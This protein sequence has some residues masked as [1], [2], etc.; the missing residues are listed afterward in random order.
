VYDYADEAWTPGAAKRRRLLG[1][2]FGFLT[3]ASKQKGGREASAGDR[4]KPSGKKESAATGSSLG[5][6]PSSQEVTETS[7]QD[8]A[9]LEESAD[10]DADAGFELLSSALQQATDHSAVRD[11]ESGGLQ[12]ETPCSSITLTGAT[13]SSGQRFRRSQE[14]QEN[15]R[16][17]FLVL[18]L[19]RLDP[20]A[21]PPNMHVGRHAAVI[22]LNLSDITLSLRDD[23]A[24]AQ[25]SLDESS[26]ADNQSSSSSTG[27]VALTRTESHSA[28]DGT[29]RLDGHSGRQAGTQSAG[30][31]A[32]EEKQAQENEISC[33]TTAACQRDKN[34]LWWEPG[35][36][37]STRPPLTHQ[38]VAA[39]L[40]RITYQLPIE[41]DLEV[42]WQGVRER[43]EGEKLGLCLQIFHLLEGAGL[44]GLSWKE[45]LV[46]VY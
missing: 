28:K 4:A 22:P 1:G 27:A 26:C 41:L 35:H 32:R 25:D 37:F 15:K 10:A 36:L 2:H 19:H 14:L 44:L 16:S 23:S 5:T 18:A 33:S 17:S 20:E 21:C 8:Q 3:K 40:E 13:N 9:G 11:E 12:V 7:T 42:L 24:Q 45:L 30:G 46:R 39:I 6:G 31:K 29:S 38:K 34:K 43:V